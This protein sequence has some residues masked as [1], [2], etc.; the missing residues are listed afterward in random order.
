MDIT[1]KNGQPS[2]EEILASI[3]RIIAEEPAGAAQSIDFNRRPIM[4]RQ[5]GDGEEA[6]EFD[7]PAIF[8][9]S[10]S[11][12]PEK[13]TPLLGRLT[14]AIRNA[15]TANGERAVPQPLETGSDG[16]G[17][18]G[19][20]GPHAE[21]APHQSLSSLKIAHGDAG[22]EASS[23]DPAPF[24]HEGPVGASNAAAVEPT[25]G[26]GQTSGEGVRRVMA[27]FKDTMFLRL[28]DPHGGPAP[29]PDT[30]SP[31]SAA[32]LVPEYVAPGVAAAE[33][34]APPAPGNQR[35]P[36]VRPVTVDFTAIVPQRLDRGGLV[37]RIPGEP[38]EHGP[39]SSPLRPV[40]AAPPVTPVA[41][42]T[43]P[44][45]QAQA[46]IETQS[47]S[48]TSSAAA[49][50]APVGTIEDATADLLRPMLR[51]WL[52]ENMPRMVEKALHIEVAESV[53]GVRKPT[54]QT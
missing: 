29:V 39:A 25:V 7:L 9:H 46:V 50:G 23:L 20:S 36:V 14:D 49:S 45:L 2:M 47:G 16:A 41:P 11:P 18:G 42:L 12:Q 37:G 28:A 4:L 27:P 44:P 3:R 43:P 19:P 21:A 51:Q 10:A 48:Q 53:K 1:Q 8:R 54:D 30:H 26:V 5:E 35:D 52:A 38:V 15:T 22:K 6:T 33:T 32:P 17:P 34:S 24:V 40:E 13:P 31:A